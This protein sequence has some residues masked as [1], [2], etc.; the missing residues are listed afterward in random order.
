MI[1][2]AV[3]MLKNKFYPLTYSEGIELESGQYVLVQTEKGEEA[4]RVFLVNSE[5]A[6]HWEKY[7]PE[8][9][10][11]IRIMNKEDIARLDDIKKEEYIAFN[12][13]K[14]L[15]ATHKPLKSTRSC[16]V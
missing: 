1:K 5:I 6:K 2:F 13:C 8:A 7:K 14:N 9:L 11:L 12:K 4:V 3:K 15:V 10:P 16:A